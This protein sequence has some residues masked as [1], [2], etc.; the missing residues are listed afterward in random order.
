MDAGRHVAV[1][2]PGRLQGDLDP[3]GPGAARTRLLQG[4]AGVSEDLATQP[5]LLHL[6]ILYL[7][8]GMEN[9]H[10]L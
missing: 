7:L 9:T 6:A 1:A 5:P 10:Q 2:R 8:P 3:C 4:D